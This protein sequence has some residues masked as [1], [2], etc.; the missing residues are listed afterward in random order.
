NIPLINIWLQHFKE[1]LKQK[2]PDTHFPEIRFD[3]LPT[4]DIDEAFCYK[5]K[6][7]WRTW[8]GYL[9]SILKNHW[10][11]V[12]ERRDVLSGRLDDPYDSFDWI[13]NLHYDHQNLNAYFFILVAEKTSRYDKNN[14]PRNKYIQELFQN[15]FN[16]SPESNKQRV[17]KPCF[18]P[19][20]H[21][22][23]QSGDK[24]QLLKKEWKIL[25][26]CITSEAR[27]ES[28]QH[29]IRFTLPQTFRHLIKAGIKDD[30]SMGY[31]S[32]NGFRASTASSFYWYDLEEE[33]TTALE[34][35]PFCYM[36]ANSFHEQKLKPEQASEEM[37]YY[38]NLVKAF[39]GTMI[40]IWHNTFLGTHR[41]FTGWRKIYLHF[42]N[43]IHNKIPIG[44]E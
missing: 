36:D 5:Y 15:L 13:R 16:R 10:W 14:S 33:Q 2:F 31:G 22:S 44:K 34:V 28:R 32:I 6:S 40:T 41:R 7:K 43:H 3:F 18:R 1:K 30:Y 21:S 35:H 25:R 27:Y 38:F 20:L 12:K 9:R 17:E 39:G 24:P 23:W 11:E 37:L 4:Y 42:I 26:D 29:F 19:G 8:G